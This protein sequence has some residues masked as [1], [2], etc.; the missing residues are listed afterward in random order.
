MNTL[1]VGGGGM[2]KNATRNQWMDWIRKRKPWAHAKPSRYK[3][4][5]K[6]R[7]ASHERQKARIDPE[8][9]P[10]YGRYMGYDD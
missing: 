4:W 3:Q 5:A 9:A 1:K 2:A 10:T 7:K 8:C 6:K